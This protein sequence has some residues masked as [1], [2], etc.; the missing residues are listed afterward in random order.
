MG[1]AAQSAADRSNVQENAG[2]RT[3]RS[4]AAMRRSPLRDPLAELGSTPPNRLGGRSRENRDT[5][6]SKPI[7]RMRSTSSMALESRFWGGGSQSRSQS[8]RSLGRVGGR[9]KTGT[10]IVY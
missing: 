4:S 1:S 8:S 3:P 10:Y 6:K 7:Y 9:N 5:G 2:P